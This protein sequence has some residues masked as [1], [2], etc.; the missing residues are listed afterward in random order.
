MHVQTKQ[1]FL[2]G[3]RYFINW[4]TKL[5]LL[6]ILEYKELIYYAKEAVQR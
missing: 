6:N 1:I 4:D 3:G 2:L 5:I